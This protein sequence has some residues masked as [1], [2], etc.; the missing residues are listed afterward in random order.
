MSLTTPGQR[1]ERSDYWLLIEM[2]SQSSF[3]LFA[4]RPHLRHTCV[5][6][7]TRMIY[8]STSLLSDFLSLHSSLPIRGDY[9]RFC[10]AVYGRC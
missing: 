10:S 2:G 8:S 1:L 7:F 5:G 4:A 6:W 3:F 9:R